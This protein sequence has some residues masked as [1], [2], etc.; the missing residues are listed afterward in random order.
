MAIT[1]SLN[2][3]SRVVPTYRCGSG[4]WLTS[5]TIAASDDGGRLV[6]LAQLED[7]GG[8]VVSWTMAFMVVMS[9]S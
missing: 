8:P 2:A 5:P 3:S 9:F 4:A 6:D 7:L 1:P